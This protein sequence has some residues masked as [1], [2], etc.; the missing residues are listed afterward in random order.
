MPPHIALRS[1]RN[2]LRPLG[3]GVAFNDGEYRVHTFRPTRL[4]RPLSQTCKCP[5]IAYLVGLKLS[6]EVIQ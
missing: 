5:E 1:T 3:V 4:G 6:K 2:N